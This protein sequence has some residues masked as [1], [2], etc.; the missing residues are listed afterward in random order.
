[1]MV[2]TRRVSASCLDSYLNLIVN[3]IYDKAEAWKRN[4]VPSKRY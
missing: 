1:M 4:S 2:A 3:V